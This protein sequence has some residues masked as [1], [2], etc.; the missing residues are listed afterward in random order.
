MM[1]MIFR[2]SVTQRD[3][4][5]KLPWLKTLFFI[6]PQNRHEVMDH[7]LQLQVFTGDERD[8]FGYY[9]CRSVDCGLVFNGY[10]T[11]NR[12]AQ[13]YITPPPMWSIHFCWWP[14]FPCM[15]ISGFHYLHQA[16]NPA[17]ESSYSVCRGVILIRI[18]TVITRTEVGA[19]Q[20]IFSALTLIVWAS[21]VLW[22]ATLDQLDDCLRCSC[23]FRYNGDPLIAHFLPSKMIWL[24][25]YQLDFV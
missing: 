12:Y 9:F 4:W 5:Q 14:R 7:N 21:R 8:S 17:T 3:T 19:V 22:T 18:T 23:L 16:L 24:W 6:Y 15:K 2:Y 1:R 20:A 13:F 11:R 10:Q 25:I